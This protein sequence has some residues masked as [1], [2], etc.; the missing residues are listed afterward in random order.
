M[1]VSELEKPEA[2]APQTNAR[3]PRIALFGGFGIGNFGNDASLEALLTFMR[4]EYPE[5]ELS[6]ICTKP[7]GLPAHISLP[8]TRLTIAP[9]GLVGKLNTLFLR[10]PGALASWVHSFRVLG[11][12]D[13]V[14]AAGT[15][16]FDDFRDSPFGWP[17][18][19][20][21]WTL[22]ARLRGVRFAFIS[23]GAGPIISPISR[24][25][26]KRAALFAE[27]RSYRDQD[28]HDFMRSIGV[29]RP[30]D[31]V[32]PDLAF[33]LPAPADARVEGGPLTVGVGIMNYRGWRDSEAVYQSYLAL[34]IRLIEWLQAQGHVVRLV[35]GQAPA[36]LIAVRDIET[37]LGCKLSGPREDGMRS[38]HDAMAAIAETDIVIASR[39]H[40]QIAALKMGRPLLSLSYAPKNEALMADAGLEG[41]SQDIT[42]DPGAVDF[43]RLT[44]QFNTLADGRDRYTAIVRERVGA[45]VIRL[46]DA[47]RRLELTAV[48]PR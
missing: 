6:C 24:E 5:A 25:L 27:H 14:L 26:M 43:E 38:I 10:G 2:G 12:V 42:D 40:V 9:R 3:R 32:L 31:V 19:L 46:R 13:A 16:V 18:R 29:D 28:S 22:A 7:E 48:R 36:D 44:G 21:R 20:L 17:S 23:V 47:L 11:R 30:G 39:Y 35:I 4:E 37:R 33:L 34:Q 1:S 45:M 41:F 8:A 15:G